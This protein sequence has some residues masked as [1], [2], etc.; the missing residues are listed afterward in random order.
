MINYL[1]E[2]TKT[3]L[4][5]CGVLGKDRSVSPL[6][7]REYNKLVS[8]LVEQKLRPSDLLSSSN[9]KQ[10]SISIDFPE[11][12]LKMLLDR[13]VQLGFSI[14]EWERNGI[15]ILSRSDQAYPLR[16]KNQLGI[17]AP[18]LIY[19]VGDQS[20]LNGGGLGIVGS[21]MID[22]ASI[23][24][25]SFNAEQCVRAG[26]PVV[27][28]GARGV[29]Q[30]AMQSALDA[31][32]ITIGVLAE[33]LL[34]KS[35]E[36]NARKAIADGQL[37]MISPYNPE[38]PFS[39]GAAMGRNKLIYAMSDYG[40]VVSAE[41]KKGGTWAGAEEE[42]KRNNH[43][44]VF[45]KSGNDVPQGNLKL[46][47]LGALIWPNYSEASELKD[48]LIKSID[49]VPIRAE[50]AEFGFS[51]NSQE[52]PVS[53]PKSTAKISEE[54]SE[55]KFEATN[56][57]ISEEIYQAVL[58]IL[59]KNL[60]NPTSRDDLAKMLNIRKPQLDVWLKQA[61]DDRRVKKTNNPVLY[62]RVEI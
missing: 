40:L 38:T 54:A 62:C 43:I 57:K 45:V 29:D 31:G 42:L 17:K 30:I 52:N 51:D 37:L 50:Q 3:T 1:T 61:I 23:N 14:E 35:L 55:K 56:L 16:L 15:W 60:I 13:G 9:I 39:V 48:M 8:W 49:S 5:L 33:N 12:R 25:T 27:S 2:D 4:L 22:E 20:L 59:L 19:G 41:Y 18:P 26:M 10:A 11:E 58:P 46:L 28:G 7:L 36:R 32:G 47:D 21:R 24:F 34:K 6:T 44:P 53:I